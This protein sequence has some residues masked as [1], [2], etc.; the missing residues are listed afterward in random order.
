MNNVSEKYNKMKTVFTKLT[1]QF[2]THLVTTQ[3]NRKSIDVRLAE[4]QKD[5]DRLRE[6][7]NSI[8]D[9]FHKDLEM[10]LKDDKEARHGREREHELGNK[11]DKL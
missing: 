4:N 8:I 9:D 2:R 7:V 11:V 5:F 1:E 3:A 10:K 6:E